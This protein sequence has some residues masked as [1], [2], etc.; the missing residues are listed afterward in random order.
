VT[1]HTYHPA[2]EHRLVVAVYLGAEPPP[3]DSETLTA[4]RERAA[5]LD[6]RGGT[7]PPP[8]NYKE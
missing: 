6:A 2:G 1:V 8:I 7:S 5:G 3:I 4:L